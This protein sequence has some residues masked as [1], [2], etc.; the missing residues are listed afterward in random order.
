MTKTTRWEAMFSCSAQSKS[1]DCS[2]SFLTPDCL[3]ESEIMKYFKVNQS[4]M[5]LMQPDK[6]RYLWG[7][8]QWLV[9][10]LMLLKGI[11][12]DMKNLLLKKVSW[13]ARFP[14]VRLK[15][16]AL[17]IVITKT[18]DSQVECL[19][20]KQVNNNQRKEFVREAEGCFVS[21]RLLTRSWS[22]AGDSGSPHF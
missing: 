6:S 14:E 2:N 7:R 19:I 22:Q 21:F 4:E 10:A 1:L 15:A 16:H 5:I 11:K 9:G 12:E 18:E 20:W 17:V 8:E 13:I 3:P